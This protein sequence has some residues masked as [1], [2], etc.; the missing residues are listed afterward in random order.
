MNGYHVVTNCL[1]HVF[2]PSGLLKVAKNC[3][4]KDKSRFKTLWR[5]DSVR[6]KEIGKSDLISTW[7][8]VQAVQCIG[9]SGGSVQS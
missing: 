5:Y 3:Q 4:K 6:D 7:L 1:G 8:C 2:S 9:S